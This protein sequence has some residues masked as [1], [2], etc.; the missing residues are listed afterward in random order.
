MSIE[1]ATT[2]H[3]LSDEALAALAVLLVDFAEADGADSGDSKPPEAAGTSPR[4]TL[5]QARGK[6]CPSF[7][8][9]P[10]TQAPAIRSTPAPSPATS[11]LK[12]S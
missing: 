8:D 7:P 12:K 11:W 1:V 4:P 10:Y 5:P 3:E 9:R 2:D 6:S